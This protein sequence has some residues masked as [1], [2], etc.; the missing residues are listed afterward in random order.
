MSVTLELAASATFVAKLAKMVLVVHRNSQA[1]LRSLGHEAYN[2]VAAGDAVAAVASGGGAIAG[3]HAQF[4]GLWPTVDCEM[5]AVR[6]WATSSA[7]CTSKPLCQC[8][9]QDIRPHAL[10]EVGG[11]EGG[12]E[13]GREVKRALLPAARCISA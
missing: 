9:F 11:R 8:L 7:A 13:R 6:S 1:P 12:R 2:A 3:G 10:K 4:L 5:A